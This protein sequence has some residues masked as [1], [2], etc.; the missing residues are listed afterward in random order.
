MVRPTIEGTKSRWR[1]LFALLYHGG[2]G[3]GEKDC[4]NGGVV[5]DF[6]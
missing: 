3:N 2:Y 6:T 5:K 4:W 1:A